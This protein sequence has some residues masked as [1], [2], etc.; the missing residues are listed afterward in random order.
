MTDRFAGDSF[1]DRV[2]DLSC[3]DEMQAGRYL[4]VNQGGCLTSEWHASG[5]KGTPATATGGV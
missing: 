1:P 5:H 4:S 3:A 2:C